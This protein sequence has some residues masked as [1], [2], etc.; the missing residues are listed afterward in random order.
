[1]KPLEN[2]ESGS[3]QTELQVAIG[4]FNDHE[5]ASRVAASLRR[6]DI[7]V[8]KISKVDPA[9]AGELPRISYEDID[10]IDAQNV[11]SGVA[12]GGA[13]GLGSGLLFLG[14]PG[15][16]LAAPIVGSLVGAWIGGIAGVAE[17][18]R[19]I[20]L[21]GKD[22]YQNLL[23]RGKSLVV[24][25]GDESVRKKLGLEMESLGAEQVHQHP[26]LAHLTR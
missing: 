4:V 17:A 13:V 8:K 15:L 10:E 12:V 2:I 1:M 20:R 24:V 7:P 25:A 14:I 3:E 6:S 26:P 18:D 22:D 19:A 11:A 16:N 9:V 23:A 21:P 5:N